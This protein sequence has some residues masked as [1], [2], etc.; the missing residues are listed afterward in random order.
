M[1]LMK[2]KKVNERDY[3]KIADVEIDIPIILAPMAGVTDFPYR[4]IIRE[5]GCKLV[6]SEM[7]SSKGLVY[8]SDRSYDLMEYSVK[9]DG[10][11]TIQLFGED[12]SF[13]AEAANIVEQELKP[14]FI[15]INMGC[16]TPKIVKNGSGSAL[17]KNLDLAGD[18]IKAVV[19]AVELPVTF[20]I[21]TGWDQ[22]SINAVELALLGE[23][24][25]A[26]A[27]AVHG[28]TRE[29]FYSGKA[30]WKIIKQVKDAVSIPV[31]GNGDIFTPEEVQKILEKTRCDGVM[32]GRGCQGNPWLIK[33]SIHLLKTGK[34]LVKPDYEE[35]IEM[36]L[37]HLKIAVDYFGEKTAIP[38]MRKHLGWYIK[39]MPF[40]AELKGNINQMK[41]QEETVD[42]LLDY[43]ERL[44]N[45]DKCC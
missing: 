44:K 1:E 10:L 34:L 16:P 5:M 18:I 8:G 45:E 12:A 24:M 38:R 42:L 2:K 11:I 17:M 40:S 27:I 29:Q 35:I 13:M 20:K 41:T 33:R 28:R 37:Y 6:Y 30:N 39:G 31:I 43:R 7:V 26:K 9:N 25:G 36:A 32:I 15:D 22:E 3:M 14:D 19:E 21:R 4:Q 23:E